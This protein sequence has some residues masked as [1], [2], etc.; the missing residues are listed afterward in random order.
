VQKIKAL[1]MVVETNTPKGALSCV[2]CF[3][4]E[5]FFRIHRNHTQP[6][7]RFRD[8]ESAG[9]KGGIPAAFLR[10]PGHSG[11]VNIFKPKRQETVKNKNWTNTAEKL[12]PNNGYPTKSM[13]DI[14]KSS[15]APEVLPRGPR[16]SLHGPG[17]NSKVYY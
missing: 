4:I 16:F 14:V 3:E 7:S 17:S 11:L 9:E 6:L 10:G 5:F 12:T 2:V 8:N 13:I 15:G 1:K